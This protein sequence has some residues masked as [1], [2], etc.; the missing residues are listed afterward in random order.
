MFGVL[1]KAKHFRVGFL[2]R[3][4]DTD[5][6]SSRVTTKRRI[7][8]DIHFLVSPCLHFNFPALK[9]LPYN[10]MYTMT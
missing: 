1:W 9:E 5:K 4:T 6:K 8:N 7:T 3:I 2:L 10:F